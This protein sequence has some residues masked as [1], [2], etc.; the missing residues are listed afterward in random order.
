MN[1]EDLFWLVYNKVIMRM[2]FHIHDRLE[3]Q[4]IYKLL[5]CYLLSTCIRSPDRIP[6]QSR[7]FIVAQHQIAVSLHDEHITS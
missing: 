2:T 4:S 1:A 6:A 5:I 7:I 3:Q